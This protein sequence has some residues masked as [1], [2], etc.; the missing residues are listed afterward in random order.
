MI[1]WPIEHYK[2]L[3]ISSTKMIQSSANHDIIRKTNTFIYIL[4][5]KLY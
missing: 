4:K 3:F 1:Q 5:G 2:Q